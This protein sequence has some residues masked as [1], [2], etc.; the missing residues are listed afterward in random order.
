M[1]KFKKIAILIAIFLFGFYN[2]CF[3]DIVFDDVVPPNHGG[4]M[5]INYEPIAEPI[6]SYIIIGLFILII[7]VCAAIIIRRIIKKKKD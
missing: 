7:V 6:M 4:N 2:I 1:K 5:P 3:A